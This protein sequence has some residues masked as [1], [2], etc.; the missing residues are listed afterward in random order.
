[1]TRFERQVITGDKPQ[2][3]FEIT[4]AIGPSANGRK[5]KSRAENLTVTHTSALALCGLHEVT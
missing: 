4:I 5:F 3:V 2:A 1:M